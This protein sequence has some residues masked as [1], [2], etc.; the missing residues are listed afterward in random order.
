M[1]QPVLN[2]GDSLAK[3]EDLVPDTQAAPAAPVKSPVSS[4]VKQWPKVE[5]KEDS[6]EPDAAAIEQARDAILFTMAETFVRTCP[7]AIAAANMRA[8]LTLVQSYDKEAG[9]EP[10]ATGGMVPVN[11]GPTGTVD[12]DPIPVSS[13]TTTDPTVLPVDT[14]LVGSEEERAE[15]DREPQ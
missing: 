4:I 11:E 6:T 1:A 7:D 13:T 10:M 3:P 15:S 9:D 12:A 2:A 5:V 14:K 8:L